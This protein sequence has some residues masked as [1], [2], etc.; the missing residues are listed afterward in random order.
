MQAETRVNVEQASKRTMRKPTRLRFGE[1]RRPAGQTS[2]IRLEDSAGVVT[3]ACMQEESRPEHGKPERWKRES[4]PAAREG[5]AGPCRVAERPVVA[6]KPGNAG[7]AK[8]PW[9]R[10][11][12]VGDGARRV[13]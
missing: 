13:A 7:G 2:D 10:V 12:V 11:S 5:Q 8:G 9:F 3:S 6:R 1:G 4:E